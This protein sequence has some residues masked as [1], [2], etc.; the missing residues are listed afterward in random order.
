MYSTDIIYGSI[1]SDLF[2]ALARFWDL[3]GT[4]KIGYALGFEIDFSLRDTILGGLLLF[5]ICR[6]LARLFDYDF[7]ED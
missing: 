3:L 1:I 4:I 6:C 5:I 2:I 7:E